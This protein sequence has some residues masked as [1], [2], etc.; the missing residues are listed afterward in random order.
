[1]NAEYT[2]GTL[3]F[4]GLKNDTPVFWERYNEAVNSL[5]NEQKAWISEQQTVIQKKTEMYSAFI[6]YLFEKEKDA[7]VYSGGRNVSEEYIKAVEFASSQYVDKTK[8]LEAENE[9][10][11]QRLDRLEKMYAESNTTERSRRSGENHTEKIIRENT[12]SGQYSLDF[13]GDESKSE[14]TDKEV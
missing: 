1:M 7:F 3:D 2:Y 11:K 8:R 4:T 10:L 9:K 12:D 6:E 14:Q 13:A 5:S